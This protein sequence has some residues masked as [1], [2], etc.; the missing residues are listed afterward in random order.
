MDHP[1]ETQMDSRLLMSG[2]MTKKFLA[3]LPE[4]R[5]LAVSS[6]WPGAEALITL[7]VG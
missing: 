4:H 7:E 2:I 5:F 3:V 1:K 6:G